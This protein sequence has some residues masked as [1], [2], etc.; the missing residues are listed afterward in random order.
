[1]KVYV[2]GNELIRE[3]AI[4]HEV[5][6]KLH[7]NGVEF[8]PCQYAEQLIEAFMNEGDIVILDAVKGIK[9]VTLFDDINAFE[10]HKPSTLHDF[11]LSFFLKLLK[12]AG[13]LKSK[14]KIIGMPTQI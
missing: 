11:D 10:S 6:K 1:M 9:E 5:A 14:V 3:D 2:F 12:E 7:V 4:A 8:V 13:E